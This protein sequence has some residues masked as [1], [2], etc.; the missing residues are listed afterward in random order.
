MR[1]P[2]ASASLIECVMKMLVLRFSRTR[3][4]NSARSFSPVSSSSD[5]NGS[6][7]QQDLRIHRERA[8][9]RDALAH[10]AGERVR[11]GVLVA[12]QA[13]AFEPLARDAQP[14]ALRDVVEL[15]AIGDVLDRGA[16][17]QQAV[18]LEDDRD[19]AA[20]PVEVAKRIAAV[21]LAPC[22]HVGSISPVRRLN[23]VDLPQPVL[24]TTA[25]SSPRATSK[26]RSRTAK[27]GSSRAVL[28]GEALRH[29]RESG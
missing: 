9:D 5:E 3:R 7:Q 4:T 6:S 24:P 18:A 22:P 15:E 8:R 14:L 19:L 10:A 12:F 16:P 2:S 27:S 25:I 1:S 13:Q 11:I 28:V 29:G 23:I 26:V 17:G 21:D 20:E